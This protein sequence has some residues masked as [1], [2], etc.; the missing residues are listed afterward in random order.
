MR[1]HTENPKSVENDLSN[2]DHPPAVH[3][4]ELV[5]SRTH[6][7][8]S[9]DDNDAD[10]WPHFDPVSLCYPWHVYKQDWKQVK[11]EMLAGL[12]VAFA[13]VPESVAFAFLAGENATKGSIDPIQGLQAAWIVGL[14]T[15]VFGG[16]TTMISGST[17]AIAAV[18][19]LVPDK[20]DIY[21]IIILSGCLI[22]LCGVF[23]LTRFARL[24]PHSAMIGFVNGLAIIIATSQ[25]HVFHD[26]HSS[27]GWVR[28]WPLFCMILLALITFGIVFLLPKLT[29]VVPSSLA[30][31]LVAIF[32]EYVIF[33]IACNVR[34]KTI[35]DLGRIS[36]GFPLP[37]F[38]DDTHELAPF[39]GA[40]LM[41]FLGASLW[42]TLVAIS[43]DVMTIEVVSELT[44]TRPK[45]AQQEIKMVQQ[46]I[47]AMGSANIIAGLFGTIGG[48]STIGLS[49]I[50]CFAGSNGRYRLSA[51][52]VA[53][54]V[55]VVV[56][57]AAPVIAA[58]PAA[59]LVGIMMAVV[60]HTFEWHSVVVV[61]ATILPQK[62]RQYIQRNVY[63]RSMRKIQ[64]AD[65]FV[66]VLVTVLTIL[67]NLGVA[68]A[69]GLIFSS[70]VY[71]W[72]SAHN[73]KVSTECVAG[74]I[75]NGK[76]P[77][78]GDLSVQTEQVDGIKVYRLDGPLFFGNARS[79]VTEFSPK[80]D[81]DT[82]EIHLR[83]AYIY[84]FS[85]INALNTIGEKYKKLGKSIHLKHIKVKSRKLMSKA[86]DLLTH[87]TYDT[88]TEV[89]TKGD[90]ALHSS[91]NLN[92]TQP[93]NVPV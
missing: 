70:L 86:H 25:L 6:A 91:Y 80:S 47:I 43:E 78:D 4:E 31:I 7:A 93:T 69:A 3:T 74:A 44:K 22:V 87:F 39:S 23:N 40:K 1:I 45:S 17:G 41:E 42:I 57:V 62:A 29:R 51:L 50:N 16:R 73:L 64:R 46:Q 58:I 52:T 33:G 26:E 67:V 77:I 88:I 53:V 8:P 32:I 56:L 28:G 85:A 63:K 38:I 18:L 61:L 12:V 27:S 55:F 34:T 37:I 65:A 54:F 71:S 20:N 76:Q 30:A 89:D 81:P 35:G 21:P 49:M 72:Q 68:I 13:Q 11:N 24:I 82:V 2:D 15:S 10:D 84:D 83:D 90:I 9:D 14:I 59:A 5:A 92:V 19:A 75:D 60:Y 66:I 36:G 79:F 48:G